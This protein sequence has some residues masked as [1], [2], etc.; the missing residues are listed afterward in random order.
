MISLKQF[1]LIIYDLDGTLVD[2]KQDICNSVNASLQVIGRSSLSEEEISDYVGRGVQHLMRAALGESYEETEYNAMF[3]CFRS[4]Y[5]EHQLDHSRAY[6]GVVEILE[7]FKHIP[8]SV[9]TNKPVLYAKEILE[10]LDL[11]KYFMEV[12]GG[13]SGFGRKPSPKPIQHLLKIH[14]VKPEHAV[15][16][17]DSQMDIAAAKAAGIRAIAVTYGFGQ[18][19]DLLLMSPDYMI[20]SIIDLKG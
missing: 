8:T 3:D 7:T 4:H 5:R 18:K 16:I 1:K 6:P 17:G 12:I 20:N 13:D 15:I 10:G 14:D 9:V 11:I 19:E 2:T